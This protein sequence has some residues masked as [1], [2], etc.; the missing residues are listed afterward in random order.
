M[1][2]AIR[3]IAAITQEH[4]YGPASIERLMRRHRLSVK[5]L[6]VLA[7]VSPRTARLWL[8][9]ETKP[10]APS[11]RMLQFIDECP[12]TINK[13]IERKSGG[14]QPRKLQSPKERS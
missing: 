8:L 4:N 10:C 7:N 2:N 1:G 9:G 12:E 5:G 3:T 14:K 13:Y 11:C 6:A